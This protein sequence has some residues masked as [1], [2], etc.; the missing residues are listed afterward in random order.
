MYNENLFTLV[1]LCSFYAESYI[2]LYNTFIMYVYEYNNLGMQL[3]TSL[4]D[5]YLCINLS[6]GVSYSTVLEIEAMNAFVI[7]K[8][9]IFA[10]PNTNCTLVDGK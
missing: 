3:R 8:F 9:P 4:R 7:Y 5:F 1:V 10:H 2:R 6:F